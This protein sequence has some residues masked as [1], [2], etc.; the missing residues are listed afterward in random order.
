MQFGHAHVV[1][2]YDVL[3]RLRKAHPEVD[4]ESCSSGGGRVDL[5][6]LRR[7]DRVWTSDCNDALDRQRIQCGFSMLFPAE[8]M[9]GHVGPSRAQTSGRL[10]PLGLRLATA[11]FGHMGF[12]WNLL[13]A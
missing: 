1:G 9:G 10:Q 13:D 3:D 4:V 6:V 12:E 7:T 5:G 8:V 2:L 11:M